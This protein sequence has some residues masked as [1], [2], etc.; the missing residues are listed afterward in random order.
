MS[1]H[2]TDIKPKTYRDLARWLKSLPAEVLDLPVLVST[3]A[4][5]FGETTL[6]PITDLIDR[7]CE[8]ARFS[9]GYEGPVLLASD[10]T[11]TQT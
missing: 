6:Y 11:P 3:G 9:G 1:T 2:R 8:D 10:P 5:E 7:L 4:D